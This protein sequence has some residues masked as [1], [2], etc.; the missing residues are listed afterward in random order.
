[1]GSPLTP[2]PD[3]HKIYF[4]MLIGMLSCNIAFTNPAFAIP[5]QEEIAMSE[6]LQKNSKKIY[7]AGGCF[8]GVEAYFARMRGVLDVSSGYSN[9]LTEN[10]SYEDVTQNSS[11]HAETVE[12]SYDPEKI[13]LETLIG[14]FFKIIDPLSLN[15]QGNDSGTQYRTGIYYIDKPDQAIIAKVVEE[16][17]KKYTKAIVVEVIPLAQYFLAEDYHQDYLNKNPGGYCHINLGA[18]ED[19][20]DADKP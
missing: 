9:G 17:Q 15:R 7:F 5:S 20:M 18:F 19:E 14:R 16:V 12:V 6:E 13:S 2:P 11:G 10:P 1:M 8:W 3:T 4:L